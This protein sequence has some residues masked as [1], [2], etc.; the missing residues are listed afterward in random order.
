MSASDLNSHMMVH[1]GVTFTCEQCSKTCKS[2]KS[3][4][5]HMQYHIKGPFTCD[6]Y[7]KEYSL[8]STLTN[9]KKT[10]KDQDYC[11]KVKDCDYTTR[12]YSGFFEHKKY[13]HLP[14]KDFGCDICEKKYQTP[15]QLSAHYN[16]VHGIVKR[17]LKPV[18]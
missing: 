12:S 7:L 13:G 14:T 2:R 3:M 10:H 11:C 17:K 16:K 6:V 5:N 8:Q 18:C 9:H 1:A 15:S 4:D